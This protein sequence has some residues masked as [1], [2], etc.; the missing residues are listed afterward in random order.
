MASFF[1]L[2]LQAVKPKHNVTFSLEGVTY[3]GKKEFEST[4]EITLS[5]PSSN[6]TVEQFEKELLSQ[7]N[8]FSKSLKED[9][10]FIKEKLKDGIISYYHANPKKPEPPKLLAPTDKIFPNEQEKKVIL[11]TRSFIQLSEPDGTVIS[12]DTFFFRKEGTLSSE[13]LDNLLATSN[14][15]RYVYKF[16][17]EKL[18]YKYQGLYFPFPKEKDKNKEDIFKEFN[19]LELLHAQVRNQVTLINKKN[20]EKKNREKKNL[21]ISFSKAH[22]SLTMRDF[23]K[24]M[25]YELGLS[26]GQKVYI[27]DKDGQPYL[28]TASVKDLPKEQKGNEYNYVPAHCALWYKKEDNPTKFIDFFMPYEGRKLNSKDVS[29][30]TESLKQKIA[31]KAIPF[32]DYL[33][34]IGT[35]PNAIHIPFPIQHR[36]F[37]YAAH[38]EMF[39]RM[40]YIDK[41]SKLDKQDVIYRRVKLK[42][43]EEEDEEA[44]HF[45][46]EIN[47]EE[48]ETF[49][50]TKGEVQKAL[51]KRKKMGKN[52]YVY[53]LDGKGQAIHVEN[54]DQ[55]SLKEETHWTAAFTL[56]MFD[57]G[58]SEPAQLMFLRKK[59]NE[60]FDNNDYKTILKAIRDKHVAIYPLQLFIDAGDEQGSVKLTETENT[61]SGVKKKLPNR[62]YLRIRYAAKIILEKKK[63]FITLTSKNPFTLDTLQ[64]AAR[65]KKESWKDKK[66][67][68]LP[69]DDEALFY[70]KEV[71]KFLCTE[72]ELKEASKKGEIELYNAPDVELK[73]TD[74][75]GNTKKITFTKKIA[76]ENFNMKAL[77]LGVKNQ[78]T[79]SDQ[80]KV[81]FKNEAKLYGWNEAVPLHKNEF[82]YETYLGRYFI[83]NEDRREEEKRLKAG[84]TISEKLGFYNQLVEELKTKKYT[85]NNKEYK[86]MMQGDD[87]EALPFTYENFSKFQDHETDLYVEDTTELNSEKF[88]NLGL[89]MRYRCVTIWTWDESK[90]KRSILK[91]EVLPIAKLPTQHN[92]IE[93]DHIYFASGKELNLNRYKR[94]NQETLEDG[95]MIYELP[96]EEKITFITFIGKKAASKVVYTVNRFSSIQSHIKTLL[97][98]LGYQVVNIQIGS[99]NPKE[100]KVAFLKREDSVHHVL[101]AQE[102]SVVVIYLEPT[103]FW[104]LFLGML[105]LSFLSGGYRLFRLYRGGTHV[106]SSKR[107]VEKIQREGI[108]KKK[109]K[110]RRDDWN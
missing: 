23:T 37:S 87:R 93:A 61:F 56:L 27:L 42:L 71:Y 76:E 48:K 43:L 60:K 34:R 75:Q 85:K 30:F 41:D 4:Q 2:P 72:K 90:F 14:K 78:V 50:F 1:T 110:R 31:L 24:S 52:D 3:N 104:P 74:N 101:S 105:F 57:D 38:D 81:Y 16:S 94:E 83:K 106:G 9:V 29:A 70:K 89:E 26:K 55:F 100:F 97:P 79:K 45:A 77:G 99:R 5:S 39:M 82:S 6:P 54:D 88:P 103:R 53:L 59:E 98:S 13:D 49:L 33:I 12:A 46:L 109:N 80:A 58:K 8:T 51:I 96:L 47:R 20:R 66:N 69:I 107:G 35:E 92:T 86:I 91:E 73:L 95:K 25:V 11:S 108:K 65:K 21:D 68:I 63:K 15:I 40:A 44:I 102:H 64:E 18:Y 10:L 19:R 22:T 67:E 62:L 17:R 28:S 32:K 84:A 36:D 7:W